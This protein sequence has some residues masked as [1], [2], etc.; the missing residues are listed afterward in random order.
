MAGGK[1]R[2]ARNP[3]AGGPRRGA[4]AGRRRP[5]PELPSFVSPASVAA[6]FSSPAS[7]GRGRVRGGAGRRGGDTTD[8]GACHA[9]PFSYNSERGAQALEVTIDTAPCADPA[10]ASVPLYSYGP[11][12]VGGLGSHKDVDAV[13]EGAAESVHVGLGFLDSGNEEMELEL[14]ELEEEDASLT[15]KRKKQHK[16]N[17]NPGF[18]SIGGVRIYTEDISESEERSSSNE[19]SESE[20]GEREKFENDDGESDE[21]GSED[22]G[23]SETDGESS[24]SES[25]EDL[26]IGDSSSV[27]DQ[28]VA[29]YMEG[30]GGSEE[31]LSSKWIASL[32]LGDADPAEL[33][34]TDDDEDVDGFVNKG[35]GKLEGYAIMTASEQY[36]MKRPNSAE[37]KKGKGMV[38][39][40]DL[41]SMRVMGLEDMFLV[42]DVR[43][44]NRSGKGSKTGSSSSQL[45]RSWPNE[46]RKSKKYHSVPGE[47]KKHRKELIAKKR[48]QRMLSRGVDLGQINAKL[49]KMVVDQVDMVCFQPMHTRDC[50]QVQRLASIYQLKSGCQGSGKR[51]FV[52][53]TLT[54]QSSLPSADGQIRLEKLLGT[55]PEGFSVNW[56]NFKGPAGWKGLSAP[57][58]LAKH[59]ESSGKKSSSKK[60][61]SF[62]ERPVSFV[63]RGTMAE[64]VTETIAVDS[65]GGDA[66]CGKAAEINSTQLGSFEVHTKGFGSKMMAKMGFIEGTGLGKDG[67]GIVKPIQAIHRPKSLGLG[68]EF[69]SEAEAIKARTEPIKVRSEPSKVRPESRRN[70]RA[71]ETSGVGSFERHTKGFGSKM[72]AK[73]GFVPGSGLGR[74]GQGIATPLTA[75]RRPK[76]RGLGAKDKY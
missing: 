43:M 29:D 28:V 66:S 38:C 21:E 12:F 31:M 73:M 5:V 69:D 32:N 58:K 64:S 25:D 52:T 48:Q 7:G 67:Q 6:A 1:R 61:I 62:A 23:D 27:D 10:A 63:S 36:G 20:S 19:V 60:Q 46:G 47:K 18:L 50:S 26:S 34:H 45:S 59:R 49:R 40:R 70:V 76:S 56:E 42:K 51:R 30:I 16:V 3:T 39:D 44:A 68:V 4:G 65:I 8:G 74:D 13:E 2:H 71:L 11:E 17:R 41:P 15:P 55:E 9:V 22:D 75:V 14:E 24:G 35:K 33:M 37:R 57:G 54:G 53:V 72:M